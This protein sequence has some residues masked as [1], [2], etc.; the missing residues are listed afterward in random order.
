MKPLKERFEKEI[1]PKFMADHG[2]KN[3]MAA[4]VPKKV[5]INMGLGEAL[6]DKGVI[7]TY[8]KDL[9]A[10]AGQK[11]VQTRAKKSIADFSLQK[12]AV[13]GLKATLRHD[14]MWHF[15]DKLINIVLPRVKDFRG[16]SAT[17]F[18]AAGTYTLGVTEL[19]IF[20]EIDATKVVKTKGFAITINFSNGTRELISDLMRRL[21]FIFKEQ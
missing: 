5:V 1:L 20:P 7:E 18:D 10:I 16:I 9:E 12:G 19:V 8:T 4:P 17:S 21:G 13:I 14:K 3:I 11:V 2:I 6:K 15:I